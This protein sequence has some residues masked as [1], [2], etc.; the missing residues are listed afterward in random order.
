MGTLDGQVALIT[1]GARGQGRSHAVALAREGCDIALCDIAAPIDGIGYPMASE[2]D[3]NETVRLVEKEGQR[4]LGVVA[5]MRDTEQVDAFVDQAVEAFGRI[6]VLCAN[7][8]VVNFATVETMTDEMW[9]AV[10]DTNLT[11]IFKVLRAVIPTMKA[12]HYGRIIVTSSSGGRA[13]VPNLPA[14]ISAKWGLIGLVKGTALELADFGITVNAICPAA[15]AT[16][17]FFNEPT[18]RVFCPD[19]ENPTVEDFEQRLRD[20]KHGLNGRAYLQPEHVSRM[21]LHLATDLDGVMTGQVMD[22][23]LGLAAG[24]TA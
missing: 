22:V 1:G 3:L 21:V 17:L 9:D 16:D 20:H 24:R 7:H 5:D 12:A 15:V 14:Y 6:D 18:Y 11:G 19:I 8:G 10:V 2:E 4:A 13:G 23:G